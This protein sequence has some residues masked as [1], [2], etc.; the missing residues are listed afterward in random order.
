M[1]SCCK[2]AREN[3]DCITITCIFCKRDTESK[4]IF[5]SEECFFECVECKAAFYREYIDHFTHIPRTC[6]SSLNSSDVSSVNTDTSD[7][8]D[9]QS[10]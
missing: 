7:F 10:D 3:I 6:S 5:D 8:D 1:G 4:H 2:Y 9:S